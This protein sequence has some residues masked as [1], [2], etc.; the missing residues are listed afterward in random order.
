MPQFSP[1]TVSSST[2]VSGSTSCWASSAYG[3]SAVNDHTFSAGIDSVPGC[4]ASKPAATS[5]TGGRQAKSG[6][7]NN[8]GFYTPEMLNDGY[9]YKK[10]GQKF[11]KSSPYPTCYY[12]CAHRNCPVKRQLL[13]DAD[14]KVHNNYSGVHTHAP[15]Q[16]RKVRADTQDAFITIVRDEGQFLRDGDRDGAAD[17][18][19]GDRKLIVT[20]G[21]GIDPTA[22][23]CIW[24][25]YGSKAVKGSS[26]QKSY[27]RCA[28]ASCSA[29]RLVQRP[30]GASECV[31][32]VYQ[33]AH[34]HALPP[35]ETVATR[36]DPALVTI[37]PLISNPTP[38]PTPDGG[39]PMGI[40]PNGQRV[41]VMPSDG[42]DTAAVLYSTGMASLWTSTAPP[43]Q[44][45][46]RARLG[47]LPP[48]PAIDVL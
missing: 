34:N 42:Q 41:V 33:G 7:K 31:Q 2:I 13:C 27:Y 6:G 40:L 44:G 45:G 19:K 17:V 39:L 35:R 5:F 3:L 26:L 9:N 8:N 23:S 48:I 30:A 28:S 10:Y 29:K 32:V 18:T 14:G 1:A 22:D 20:L 24:R 12:R 47:D 16:M 43:A 38:C 37:T 4:V 15:P 46:V 36:P 25:K 21:P 11:G